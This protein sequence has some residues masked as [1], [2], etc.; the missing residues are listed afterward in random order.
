MVIHY[1]TMLSQGRQSPRDAIRNWLE[2]TYEE[3]SY[4]DE[5]H[6]QQI[7]SRHRHKESDPQIHRQDGQTGTRIPEKIK[8]G[9]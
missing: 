7:C 1:N 9:K 8:T 2:Q 3:E 6:N 5:K 4:D